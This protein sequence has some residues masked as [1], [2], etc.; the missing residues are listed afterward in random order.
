[1]DL[2]KLR[3]KPQ[4]YLNLSA[5]EGRAR[6]AVPPVAPARDALLKPPK[7]KGGP[8]WQKFYQDAVA[9]GHAEPERLADTLLR[10]REHA[11]ELAEA[12]HKTVILT[13]LPAKPQETCAVNSGPAKKSRVLV[14]DAARCKARTLAGKQCGFK[15]T[16]GEFCKKHAAR[17]TWQVARRPD[18]FLG[19]SAKGTLP[20]D[21]KQVVK[22]FGD[23]PACGEWRIEFDDNT[24][25]SFRWAAGSLH[26]AGHGVAAVARVRGALYSD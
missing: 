4:K 1:M 9:R 18:L 2:Q 14:P 12:R 20:A 22:V 10:S 25:A 16:C 23:V 17:P 7:E 13:S 3:P 5:A 21:L 8:L 6:A 26:I 24:L 19:Q 11:Q 15:A